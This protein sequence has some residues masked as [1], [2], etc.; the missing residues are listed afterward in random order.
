MATNTAKSRWDNFLLTLGAAGLLA[1]PLM[2]GCVADS[3]FNPADD[4]VDPVS[5]TGDDSNATGDDDDQTNAD[6]GTTLS[7]VVRDALGNPVADV[8]V[9]TSNGA[10]GTSDVDGRF[11]ITD[12]DPGERI[13]VDF[14]KSGYAFTQTPFDVLEDVENTLIQTL[15]MVDFL[16]TFS[17]TAGLDFEVEDGGPTVSLPADN[18]VDA[19]GVA[20]SGDVT[21]EATFYD[22]VSDMD[23]GNEIFAVPGDFTAVDTDGAGQVLESFGMLQV[24]LTGADGQELELGDSSSSIVLPVVV[25]DLGTAPE[26]GTVIP[27]WSYDE[28]TGKWVE[29]GSG[30][31]VLGDDGELYW[32]FEAPHFSTWNC[33]QPISTH[34]CLT[35]VVTD[36]QGAAKSGATVRAVGITYTSTT[37]ARTG[38]DGSFCL[39]VKNGET[40][41]AEISYSISG[42][43]ATQRTDPVTIPAGQ[44]SCSLGVQTCTD[45][46]TIP[47][48]IQTCVSGVVV[49]STNSAI[50]GMQ[51]VSPNGGVATTADDGS[52]CLTVPVFQTT[53]VF[54]LTEQDQAGYQPVR[55]YAQPG[56]PDCQGGCSNVAIMRPYT[57]TSCAHGDVVINGNAAGNILVEVFDEAYPDVR[58]YSTMTNT[59][60]SYCASV[61]GGTDVTVQVGSG[62][63]LCDSASFSTQGAGGA[64]CG[65]EAAQGAECESLD[66][67][68]CTL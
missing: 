35:G 66:T 65:D 53:D 31:V 14:V 28:E 20:Y 63:N 34:G 51:V 17:S 50:G 1:V 24:N 59:D 47:V 27:A 5:G 19:D 8:A 16:Q 57:S 9:T 58:V 18:F 25:Q 44:A 3:G 37:T 13:L 4:N 2:P 39:E 49:D 41:W 32:N 52:F 42:Q 26:V 55:M 61:P 45:L 68:V 29:E 67:F 46:G 12:I 21:V 7:G 33:D 30:T 62:D 6:L 15:A 60:G 43:T 22:L 36:V 38:Q 54:V 64:E 56:L 11:S 48:D 23:N 40:V 10:S